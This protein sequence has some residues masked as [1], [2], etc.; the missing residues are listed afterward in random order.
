MLLATFLLL[1]TFEREQK[2][3]WGKRQEELF[4]PPVLSVVPSS[5]PREGSPL[6]LRCQMK[7][8]PQKPA[9]RFL[10]SFHKEGHALQDRGLHPGFFISVAGEGDSGLYWCEAAPEG[11]RVQKQSPQLEIRSPVSHPLLIVSPRPTRLAVGNIVELLCEAQRGSPP[12]LYSFYLKEKI[13]GNFSVPHGGA[14]S[15][16]FLVTPEQDAGNYSCEA[17]NR[18]SREKTQHETLSLNDRP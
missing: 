10:F 18:V 13:L 2:W 4:L 15:F 16:L 5:K 11:G 6:T 12:I 9:S 1:I 7:L 17:E 14:T 8:H 3:P